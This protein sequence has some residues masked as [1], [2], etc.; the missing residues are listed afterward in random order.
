ML[1]NFSDGNDFFDEPEANVITLRMKVS[2]VSSN[3]IL[4]WYERKKGFSLKNFVAIILVDGKVRF[5]L[6]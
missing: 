3:G 5:M 6:S 2:T 4:L 1:T